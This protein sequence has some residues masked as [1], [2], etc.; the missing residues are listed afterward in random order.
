[1]CKLPVHMLDQ[2]GGDQGVKGGRGRNGDEKDPK[3]RFV[4]D[5]HCRQ[6]EV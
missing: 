4:L 3:D 2:R 5:V 6:E 1:M